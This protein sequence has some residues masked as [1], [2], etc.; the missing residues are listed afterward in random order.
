MIIEH[1]YK[2]IISVEIIKPTISYA[3]L[4]RVFSAIIILKNSYFFGQELRVIALKVQFFSKMSLV[5]MK[6]TR[7]VF[8]VKSQVM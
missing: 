3:L 4:R 8:L 2:I 1:I 7:Q 6:Y 5:G